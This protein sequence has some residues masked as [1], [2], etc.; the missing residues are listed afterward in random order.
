MV[1]GGH[2]CCTVHLQSASITHVGPIGESTPLLLPPGTIKRD[3][4]CLRTMCVTFFFFVTTMT[5]CTNIRRP[6]P[7]Y[8]HLC[9]PLYIHKRR[10]RD[11]TVF[12][13]AI[14]FYTLYYM[15]VVGPDVFF[16]L[17]LR[18][19]IHCMDSNNNNSSTVKRRSVLCVHDNNNNQ[20]P[21]TP[22]HLSTFPHPYSW[23][24]WK[25]VDSFLVLHH[26]I[27]TKRTF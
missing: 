21:C 24:G 12:S 1:L 2:S 3:K 6:R 14:S 15:Y 5:T 22:F 19:C 7:L 11:H 27:Y 25:E 13:R 18:H 16:I 4:I 9:T 20:S 17:L 23:V 8:A 26:H 10:T